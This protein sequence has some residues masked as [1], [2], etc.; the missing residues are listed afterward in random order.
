MKYYMDINLLPTIEVNLGFLWKKVYQQVHLALVE[1]K[2]DKGEVD[3]AL[4]FPK[5]NDKVFPL[6]DTLR[7]FS[8]SKDDFTALNLDKW[9]NNLSDYCLLSK[10]NETPTGINEYAIFKRK[11][12][13]SNKERLARRRAKRKSISYEE[14]LAHYDDFSEASTKLPFINIKSLSSDNEIKVFILQENLINEVKGS[15]N[16]FGLSKTA[17]VPLF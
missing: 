13:K 16:T 9:L 12:F 1:Q 11:Q 14:A 6:G 2:N 10:L 7:I 4:S 8:I 15:F 3:F 17:T 5:Y